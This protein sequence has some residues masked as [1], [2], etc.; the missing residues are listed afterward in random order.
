MTDAGADAAPDTATPDPCDHAFAPG[1][2]AVDDAPGDEL[3]TF[4]LATRTVVLTNEKSKIVGFDLDG[5]CSCDT[6]PETAH[7]GGQSCSAAIKVCDL[8]RGVDNS[9]SVLAAQLSPFF[10]LDAIPQKLID[11]GRR[12][13]LLQIGKYNG[14]LNDKEIAFGVALSDG[15]REPG[16]TG[17]VANAAKDI[18]SPVWCGDDHWSFLPESVIPSTKQPL[19]Q[20]L[21]YVRDGI[22]TLKISNVLP[23]PFDESSVLPLGSTVMTGNLVPLGEDLKPRDRARPPT[24]REKRLFSLENAVVGGR[25]RSS[26]LLAA[27]GAIETAGK[28]GGASTYLCQESS[29]ALLRQGTCDAVDIPT[30]QALDFDPGAKCDALSVAIAFTASPVLPGEV[31]ETNLTSNPCSPGTDGQPPDSGADPPYRCPPK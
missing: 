15:I 26:D 17:S 8:A 6:H 1:P 19:V 28:D 18:W 11:S 25:I 13:L 29:F 30:N 23:V 12:T 14:R 7:A 31:H 9:V 2:P 16:C 5:V 10:S 20:G 27:L 21:G 4:F 24:E 3:P 22:I